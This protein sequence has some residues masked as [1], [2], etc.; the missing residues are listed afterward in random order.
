MNWKI[1]E[2]WIAFEIEQIEYRNWRMLKIWITFKLK[3]FENIHRLSINWRQIWKY[4]LKMKWKISKDELNMNW[5]I[6]KI[7][8]G[9][10]IERDEYLNYIGI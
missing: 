3:C 1:L 7:W 8:I 4:E 5:N 6:L 2:I 10:E 9:F